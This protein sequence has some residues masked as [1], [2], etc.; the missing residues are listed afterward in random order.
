MNALFLFTNVGQ[1]VISS[2]ISISSKGSADEKHIICVRSI[3]LHTISQ[4]LDILLHTHW[5]PKGRVELQMST[6]MTQVQ[7]HF[8]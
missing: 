2:P 1:D 3:L 8:W 4:S 6:A 5:K 7:I